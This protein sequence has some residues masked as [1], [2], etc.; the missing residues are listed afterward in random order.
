MVTS[1]CIQIARKTVDEAADEQ[2]KHE[3]ERLM[4]N[5]PENREFD[6]TKWLRGEKPVWGGHTDAI[7]GARSN[8]ERVYHCRF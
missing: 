1:F 2:D 7:K 4:K 8:G 6:E 3:A 5:R